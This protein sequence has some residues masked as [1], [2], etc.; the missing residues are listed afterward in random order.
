MAWITGAP[1]AGVTGVPF[2]PTEQ[3]TPVCWVDGSAVFQ[4]TIALGSVA[5]NPVHQ[6]AHGITGIDRVIWFKISAI[7]RTGPIE[8]R[9]VQHVANSGLTA[10]FLDVTVDATNVILE[11]GANY[12]AY[13][14]WLTILYTKTAAGACSGGAGIP[15]STTAFDTGIR[16]IDGS[17]IW[18][19]TV[20]V[21][22][23]PNGSTISTAHGIASISRLVELYG[24]FQRAGPFEAVMLPRTAASLN[25][26]D[27]C[28]LHLTPSDIVLSSNADYSAFSGFVTIQYVP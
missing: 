11:A 4:K 28:D 24:C 3:P 26:P 1:A 20:S 14:G 12:S 22:A 9:P 21:A 27:N 7:Q 17:A 25:Q 2:T 10:E 6:V 13:Q 23:G 19:K 16:W 5:T 18:Q 8:A 15:F